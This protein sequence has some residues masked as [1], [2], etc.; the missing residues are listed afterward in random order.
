MNGQP[1]SSLSGSRDVESRGVLRY[2]ESLIAAQ[3][4]SSEI[5]RTNKPQA[6]LLVLARLV[7]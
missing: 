6:A 1:Y 4:Q 2:D 5:E 3:M 7:A